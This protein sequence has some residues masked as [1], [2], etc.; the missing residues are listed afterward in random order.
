MQAEYALG[1]G[2]LEALEDPAPLDPRVVPTWATFPS[3][4][5]PQAEAS[6]DSPTTPAIARVRNA[7]RFGCDAS[8]DVSALRAKVV[9]WFFFLGSLICVSES[10]VR[11]G[12]L[13]H[14]YAAASDGRLRRPRG[15]R[16]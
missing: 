2:E 9:I 1:F 3:D 13:Q 15:A 8:L 5:P 11:N 10:V 6:R 14:G 7:A 4:E 16:R 12:R